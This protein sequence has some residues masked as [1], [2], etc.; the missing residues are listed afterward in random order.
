MDYSLV[1]RLS[2]NE[3]RQTGGGDYVVTFDAD[4]TITSESMTSL[5]VAEGAMRDDNAEWADLVDIAA[6]HIRLGI[7]DACQQR[8]LAADVMLRSILVHPIDFRSSKFR[9]F[10]A[11]RLGELLDEVEG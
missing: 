2:V 11:E 7:E 4:V 8:G 5:V 9:Q 6:E 10:A 1:V 3:R